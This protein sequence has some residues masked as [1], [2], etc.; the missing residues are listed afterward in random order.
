M[1]EQKKTKTHNNQERETGPNEPDQDKTLL[2]TMEANAAI[3]PDATLR[4]CTS[5]ITDSPKTDPNATAA[6]CNGTAD[7][8]NKLA[9]A[10]RLLSIV[11]VHAI[12]TC[13]NKLNPAAVAVHYSDEGHALCRA[14]HNRGHTGCRVPTME[15]CKKQM[16]GLCVATSATLDTHT[17][18][19]N[20]AKLR[21]VR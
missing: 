15:T 10:K 9:L 8:K 7:G 11:G 16:A 18:G 2:K 4:S 5:I 6:P 21:S 20:L 1:L 12:P 13:N 17:T 3:C 19:T 14:P